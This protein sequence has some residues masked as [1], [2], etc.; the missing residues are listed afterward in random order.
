MRFRIGTEELHLGYCSNVHPATS[1]DEL[2]AGMGRYA[3]EIR[4]RLGA[5]RLSVTL[6][7]PYAVAKE[8]DSDT[9]AIRQL[10]AALRRHRIDVVSLNGFPCQPHRPG[11]KYGVFRP[12]WTEGPRRDYTE[13]LARILVRI[14][15]DDS[16]EGSISTLPLYWRSRA[17]SETEQKAVSA[18]RQANETLA[19]IQEESGRL[20]RVGMEPEPGCIIER[21]DEAV[22]FLSELRLSHMGLC[23]DTCHMAVQFEDP[24]SCLAVAESHQVPVVKAQLAN[25]LRATD[26]RSAAWLGVYDEAACMHQTRELRP[27]G[28]VHGVD[29]LGTAIAGGL[30]GDGEWRVHYHYPLHFQENSTQ[31]FLTRA[32]KTLLGDGA[33]VTRHLEVETY[34]WRLLPPGLRPESDED[35]IRCLAEELAWARDNL[36]VLGATTL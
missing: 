9:V 14:M 23:L 26:P 6:W 1:V 31:D 16:A 34:T 4:N 36:M 24:A 18:L 10:D 17:D 7:I 32:M 2:I 35:F 3:R 8:L 12:D 30:P 29:D 11:A 5:D 27:G 21:V 22:T 15:P 28:V 13:T 25:G 33:P 20:V 19:R